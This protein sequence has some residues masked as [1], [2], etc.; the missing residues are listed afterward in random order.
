L[1]TICHAPRTL[2]ELQQALAQ[3]TPKSRVVGGGSDLVIQMHEG[4]CEPD[5]LLYTGDILDLHSVVKADNA[6]S[7]GAAATMDEIIEAGL[8]DRFGAITDA[9]LGM[10]SV[11][12]RGVATLGGNVGSASPAGDAIPPLFLLDAEVDIATPDGVVRK[13]I[14]EVVVGAGKTSLRHDQCIVRFIMPAPRYANFRSAFVKIGFRKAVTISRIGVAVGLVLDA[15]GVAT[16]AKV[17]A[18]AIAATPVRIPK[19]EEALLGNRLT[20]DVKARVGE[21]LSDVIRKTTNRAYKIGAARG[22]A[23]DVLD[24]FNASTL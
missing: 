11:Q 20:D 1:A 3:M 18:G 13:P 8:S 6:L 2:A 16:H 21:A 15:N 9:A 14:D 7:I 5:A 10:G 24:R 23:A 19:A 12:I 17:V 4:S 22:V